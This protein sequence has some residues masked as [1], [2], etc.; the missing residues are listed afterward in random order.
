MIVLIFCIMYLMHV[1]AQQELDIY[2]NCKAIFLLSVDVALITSLGKSFQGLM[3]GADLGF[4]KG[5]GG[6]AN[7]I[8]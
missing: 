3:T 2:T 7:S 1:C 4:I 5:G 8:Y 6:G